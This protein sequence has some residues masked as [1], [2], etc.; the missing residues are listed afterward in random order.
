M[1]EEQRKAYYDFQKSSLEYYKNNKKKLKRIILI[2]ITIYLL[3]ILFIQHI[4]DYLYLPTKNQ[5]E[6]YYDIRLN[7]SPFIVSVDRDKL[8]PIFP[9]VLYL[10]KR[11]YFSS[12]PQ[13]EELNQTINAEKYLLDIA[14][15]PC[16]ECMHKEEFLA[17]KEINIS[18]KN[19]KIYKYKYF[20]KKEDYIKVMDG[21]SYINSIVNKN[22][23]LINKELYDVIYNGKLIK[24]ISEYIND[25]GLYGI[26]LYLKN[27]TLIFGLI[28]KDRQVTLL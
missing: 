2:I 12:I 6:R 16:L 28:K 19:M 25:D 7:N 18:I 23:K 20:D 24:D 1:N 26:Q 4:G 8:I 17:K 14:V 21:V 5:N 3:L 27:T 15:Y 13:K 10:D 11:K 9:Y 22:H